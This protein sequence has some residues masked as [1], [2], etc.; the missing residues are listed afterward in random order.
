MD[1]IILDSDNKWL[2]TASKTDWRE[3]LERVGNETDAEEVYVY[4]AKLLK[5]TKKEI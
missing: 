5:T 1:Y 4:E 3:E 2:A